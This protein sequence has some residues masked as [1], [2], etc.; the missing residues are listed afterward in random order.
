MAEIVHVRANTE[1]LVSVAEALNDDA[2]YL[3]EVL[4]QDLA[5]MDQLQD[6]W[7]G[8]RAE[9][10]KKKYPPTGRALQPKVAKMLELIETLKLAADEYAKLEG[11]LL[12]VVRGTLGAS[13]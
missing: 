12:V 9:R 2:K 7:L 8:P 4:K 10:F 5:D 13:Q 1:S 6:T 3:E 11:S